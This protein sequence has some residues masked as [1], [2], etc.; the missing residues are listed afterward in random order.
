MTI[1]T[2]SSVVALA[3]CAVEAE[4]AQLGSQTFV[5]VTAPAKYDFSCVGQPLPSSADALVTVRGYTNDSYS[6][7]GLP[8][9]TAMP[10]VASRS[11]TVPAI[12]DRTGTS[13]WSMGLAF[14]SALMP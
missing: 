14:G 11:M 4:P 6:C 2:L 5:D 12:G 3:A 9:V 13:L 10:S 7:S 1:L 8:G